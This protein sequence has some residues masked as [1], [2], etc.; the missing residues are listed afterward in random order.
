MAALFIPL[1]RPPKAPLKIKLVTTDVPQ[2]LKWKKSY[3]PIEIKNNLSYIKKAI[4]EKY[5]VVVLPESAFPLFLNLNEN[6]LYELYSLSFKITI[7]TGALHYKNG[8]YYNSTYV[9]ENGNIKILDKHELVPFGEYIPLPFFQK[10][11]NELFF[12]NASDYSTSSRFGIFKIKNIKFINAICYEAT[13]EKLYD[14]KPTYVMAI[15]NDAWFTPSIEPVLQKMLIK[16]FAYTHYKVVY[17]AINGY[18][19]YAIQ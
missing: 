3:I 6:L 1:K 11:I 12:G 2:N 16:L 14:L 17:H 7:V 8:K 9:F 13:I 10:Q 4:K 19:S 5:Q 15:T 18:K